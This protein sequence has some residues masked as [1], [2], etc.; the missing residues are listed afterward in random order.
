M[1]GLVGISPIVMLP[2][3]VFEFLGL[4]NLSLKQFLMVLLNIGDVLLIMAIVAEQILIKTVFDG[5]HSH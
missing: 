4:V 2:A 1:L 5:D 3:Q